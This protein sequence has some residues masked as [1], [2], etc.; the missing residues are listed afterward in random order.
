MTHPIR[1]IAV[2]LLTLFVVLFAFGDMAWAQEPNPEFDQNVRAVAKQMNCPTCAGR[3]L[4]DCPTET[5]AQWKAEIKSQLDQGKNADEVLAYFQDRFGPTV[6][7]QPPTSGSTFWLWAVSIGV[8][9][10]LLGGGALA[11]QRHAHKPQTAY[12]NTAAQATPDTDPFVAA[13]EKDVK[14]AS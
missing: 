9:L 7:Q 13:L 10:M 4:A 8:A 6:L 3:N 1:C 14:D 5:C 11:A 2:A 12:A